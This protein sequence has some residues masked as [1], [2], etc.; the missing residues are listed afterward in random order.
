MEGGPEL[1]SPTATAARDLLNM[2]HPGVPKLPA[3]AVDQRRCAMK[4]RLLFDLDELDDRRAHRLALAAPRWQSAALAYAS[5]LRG[6]IKYKDRDELQPAAD[7]FFA[8]LTAE[9]LD[10]DD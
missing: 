10:L 1:H 7:E 8:C 3:A 9:G 4:A 2:G 5:W 6:Q